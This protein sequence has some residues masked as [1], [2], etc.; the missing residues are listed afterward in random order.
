MAKRTLRS[1][2]VNPCDYCSQGI[3]HRLVLSRETL[4]HV[5]DLVRSREFKAWQTERRKSPIQWN[6][7]TWYISGHGRPPLIYSDIDNEL[8]GRLGIGSRKWNRS[9][10]SML[11]SQWRRRTSAWGSATILRGGSD[12]VPLGVPS[13]LVT[14]SRQDRQRTRSQPPHSIPNL[15]LQTLAIYLLNEE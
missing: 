4:R 11:G 12:C 9:P 7:D 8:R 2:C 6:S 10:P 13:P 5:L 14:K 1:K 3:T 15:K